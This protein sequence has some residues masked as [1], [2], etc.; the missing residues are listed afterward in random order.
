MR[1]Y[2]S[3]APG[4]VSSLESRLEPGD[5]PVCRLCRE[6]YD[7]TEEDNDGMCPACAGMEEE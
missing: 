6:E 7:G 4:G 3:F 1:A 5:A 2:L